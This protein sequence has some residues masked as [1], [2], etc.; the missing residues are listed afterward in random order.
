MATNKD[1]QKSGSHNMGDKPDREFEGQGMNPKSGKTGQGGQMAGGSQR[2][3]DDDD[4]KT[5]GGRQGQFSDTSGEKQ[6][7]WSP[8]SSGSS[9]Q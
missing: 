7:Q 6:G 9:D 8:G 4:M 1:T 3:T 5:S 2:N